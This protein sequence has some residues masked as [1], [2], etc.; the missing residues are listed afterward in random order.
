VKVTGSPTVVVVALTV[1]DAVVAGAAGRAG[2]RLSL[3]GMALLIRIDSKIGEETGKSEQRNSTSIASLLTTPPLGIA[4]VGQLM[5]DSRI[6]IA[7][8]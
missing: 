5:S 8:I 1:S 7:P 6:W 4:L 3:G 2:M